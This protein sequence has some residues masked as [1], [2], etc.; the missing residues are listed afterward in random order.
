MFRLDCLFKI[1][2]YL[3]CSGPVYA[4]SRAEERKKYRYLQRELKGLAGAALAPSRS[5]AASRRRAAQVGVKQRWLRFAGSCP[6]GCG[7]GLVEGFRLVRQDPKQVLIYF[8]LQK[9]LVLRYRISHR[10]R[11][12]FLS[13][14]CI[15]LYPRL[16]PDPGVC[17]LV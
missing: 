6:R 17:C 9:T 10:Y 1:L 4:M 14:K 16:A 7:L 3:L 13:L 5:L 11:D 15:L 2:K 12:Y 8:I